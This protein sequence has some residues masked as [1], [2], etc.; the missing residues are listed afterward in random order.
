MKNLKKILL[1]VLWV[2]CGILNYGLFLGD[3]TYQ[4]PDQSNMEEA[5]VGAVGGPFMT[6]AAL[7]V[8]GP[9]YHFLWKPYTTEQ[10]WVAFHERF[11]HL[12]RAYFDRNN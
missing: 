8:P 3:F 6:P 11:P 9:P 5:V 1:A 12:D 4:F 10:R 2:A 7:L